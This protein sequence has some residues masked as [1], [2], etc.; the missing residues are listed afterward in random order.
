MTDGVTVTVDTKRFIADIKAI[1]KLAGRAAMY[2]V[3]Q[4][5]RM[6]K[7]AMAS[8]APVYRGDRAD[9]PPGRLRKSIKV[10]RNIGNEGGEL[11]NRIGPKTYPSTAYAGKANDR[12][13]FVDAGLA[14]AE[15]AIVEVMDAAIDRVIAKYRGA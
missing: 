14:V 5:C 8:A 9:I 11:L 15:S 3:R 4:A 7:K 13:H 6:T 10:S 2:A 1:D 12:T